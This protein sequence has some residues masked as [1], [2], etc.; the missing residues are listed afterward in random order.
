[1]LVC[2]AHGALYEPDTGRCVAGPCLGARLVGLRVREREDGA[3]A[4]AEVLPP[5]ASGVDVG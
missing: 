5:A 3:I 2:A 4:V 1:M